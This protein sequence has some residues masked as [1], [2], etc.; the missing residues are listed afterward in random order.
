MFDRRTILAFLLIALILIFYDDYLRLIYPPPPA[1]P[2]DTTRVSEDTAALISPSPAGVGREWSLNVAPVPLTTDTTDEEER[3]IVVETRRFKITLSSRGARIASLVIKPFN[4][5][6]RDPVD[7]IPPDRLASLG[8]RLWTYEQELNTLDLTFHLIE[9]AEDSLI[10]LS[11]GEQREVVFAT[12]LGEGRQLQVHYRFRGDGFMFEAW[13]E[14]E[15]TEGLIVRDYCEA[16]WQGGLAYTESDTAQDE[17]YSSAF[18]YF[19]GE[20]LE[21]QKLNKK[22]HRFGPATG[23]TRWVGVRNKYFLT[24]LIPEKVEGVGAWLENEGRGDWQGRHLPNKLSAALRIPVHRGEPATALRVYAGPL[25]S[26]LLRA[27]D[28]TLIKTMSWGW[29]IIAPISK[30]ILWGLKAFYHLIPNYG[31]AV[32]VFSI[33]IKLLTWPLTQASSR[34]MLAM[35]RLQ[36]KMQALREKYKNDPQRLNR[37]IMKLYKEEKINPASG[38]LPMLLQLPVLYALF[39]VFR[40]TIEFRGA[41]F[42]LWIRDL[43][44]PDTL[45]HLPFSL[46]FYG[47]KVALL[48]LLMGVSTYFQSRLSI[49]DPNQRIFLYMMPVMMVVFFNSFPSGLTLYYTLFNVLSIIQYKLFPPPQLQ[50][51]T[52]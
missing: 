27:V 1:P 34:S 13:V 41:R 47:D 11:E 36:P 39:I 16:I 38:C 5:Y 37:E 6:I 15:G 3:R 46:P 40:S 29:S 44:M 35:Q 50:A 31:I 4:H 32:I 25:D 19:A 8:W 48:P 43:S 49:T 23:K 45:F 22:Y 26:D 9:P 24:A 28:P 12:H 17:Y 7:L 18:A 33:L 52:S 20:A 51:K 2:Q 21:E 42:V 14:G 30:A 10:A